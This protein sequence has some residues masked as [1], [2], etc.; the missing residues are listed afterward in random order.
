[1]RRDEL[2]SD[3]I[4]HLE[5]DEIKGFADLLEAFH[6]TSFQS[7]NLANCLDVYRNMLGDGE[8][9][10]V[11][12]GLSGAMVPAGLRKVVVDMMERFEGKIRKPL[13]FHWSGDELKE[14]G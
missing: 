7:R 11:F 10:T 9:V 14:L 13:S 1:M 4:R 3:P 6:Y 5:L 2:L 12:M 8:R